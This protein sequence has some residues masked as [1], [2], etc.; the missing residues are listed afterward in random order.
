MSGKWC[1]TH[2]FLTFLLSA[3]PIPYRKEILIPQVNLDGLGQVN[4]ETQRTEHLCIAFRHRFQGS[5]R[6]SLA[7]QFLFLLASLI[8][9]CHLCARHG[10][11][12]T[13]ILRTEHI[14]Q[15]SH[16]IKISFFQSIVDLRQAD[17]AILLSKVNPP[18]QH[19]GRQPLKHRHKPC[20]RQHRDTQLWMLGRKGIQHRHS[21]RR[22]AHRTKT[23]DEQPLD[24]LVMWKTEHGDK[25][26]TK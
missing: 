4:R 13:D 9:C 20:S 16:S 22:I 8:Y 1:H 17:D 6:L 7:N 12:G 23:H 19:I 21:H 25:G 11:A 26:T 18:H 24:G 15:I 10:K 14:V 5:M 2:P 3:D